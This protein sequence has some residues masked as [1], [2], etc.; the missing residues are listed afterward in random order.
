MRVQASMASRSHDEAQARPEGM[1][2]SPSI[3]APS[4]S[5]GTPRRVFSTAYLC[6]ALCALMRR[7]GVRPVCQLRPE[8]QSARK[9]LPSPQPGKRA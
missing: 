3:C 7:S 2:V 1:P 8:Y 6:I 9:K 5:S 4:S